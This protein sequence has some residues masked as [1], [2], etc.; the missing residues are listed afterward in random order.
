MKL[1]SNKEVVSV[2]ISMNFIRQ[3]LK[4]ERQNLQTNSKD[5]VTRHELFET[6]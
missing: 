3:L 2:L 5:H 1:E 4:S 6:Y